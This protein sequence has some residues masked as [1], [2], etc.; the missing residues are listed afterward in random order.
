[1]SKLSLR[2]KEIGD[3][4]LFNDGEDDEIII[5]LFDVKITFNEDDTFNIYRD[6]CF[7]I[8]DCEENFEN[9]YQTIMQEITINLLESCFGIK[10]NI[11][12]ECGYGCPFDASLVG[13]WNKPFDIDLI[14]SFVEICEKAEAEDI[15]DAVSRL[16]ME[17]VSEQA[18]KFEPEKA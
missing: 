2:Y 15:E 9:E 11:E 1:M 18:G 12:Y 16:I 3:F 14:T 7:P 5:P 10:P 6:F 4:D 17:T 8:R 13:Y